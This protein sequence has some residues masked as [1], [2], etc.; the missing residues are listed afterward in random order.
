MMP[1]YEQTLQRRSSRLAEKRWSAHFQKCNRTVPNYVIPWI[2]NANEAVVR[3]Y[4]PDQKIRGVYD[5]FTNACYYI[6]DLF[7]IFME[8]PGAFVRLTSSIQDHYTSKAIGYLNHRRVR[9]PKNPLTKELNSVLL[10][11]L[12]MRDYLHLYA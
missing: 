7:K 6:A 1:S 11:F 3:G 12:Q 2:R 10:D 5:K 9:Y 8:Y 4:C